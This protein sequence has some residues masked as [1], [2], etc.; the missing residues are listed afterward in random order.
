L[1]RVAS[2]DAL[3]DLG[4][5]LFTFLIIWAY[6][7][8]FQFMLIWIANLPYDASWYLP[9]SRGGWPWVAWA[10]FVFH[11]AAPFF[12]LLMRRVKQDPRSLAQV[13][14]V[15]LFMQLVFMYFQVLPAFEGPAW[16]K[17]LPDFPAES[18]L[19]HWMDFIMPIGLGGIWLAFFLW[20]LERY[21]VLPLHDPNQ[22]SA[23]H[24]RDIDHEE[25]ARQEE[26]HHA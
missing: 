5:L 6:V 22:E 23:I 18:I 17:V 19:V 8:F 4:N 1:A 15:I 3:N 24:L 26:L 13:A 9:R 7:V 11:F 2:P 20:Q 21:P 12:L 25:A 16:E 14:G 10:L